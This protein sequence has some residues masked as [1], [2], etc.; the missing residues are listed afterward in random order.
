MKRKLTDSIV[1][2]AKPKADGK[3][4]HLTD[5]G[6]LFLLVNQAGKYW[7]YNYRFGGK[8][9]TL[10]I[11]TYPEI[12]LKD[13]RR[14]HEEAR[15][16]LARNIDPSTFKQS[17]QSAR[18]EVAANSFEAVA[19]EWFIKH[20]ANK[21]ETHRYRTTSYLERDVFPFLGHRPISEIRPK[22]IIPVIERI[23]RRV[24]HDSH[25][26][27][28]Q[29]IGQI[30]RYAVATDRAEID[31]TASLKGL[32]TRNSEQEHFPAITDPV[33]V[34]RLLRA[35]DHYAGNFLTQCALKLSAMVMLRPA[36]LIRAEWQEIDFE[37]ETWTIEVRRM[38]A[39][40]KVKQA[41]QHRH[42]IPL[43]SQAL[44]IFADLYLLTGQGKQVFPGH[45]K[46]K[47]KSMSDETV[48]KALYRMGFKGQMTAHGF[49]GMASTLLNSM[50]LNGVRRWDADAIERQLSH[51]DKNAIR[52][53]YNRADY[54][55]ERREMLQVWAD[56]LDELKAGGQV[57]PFKSGKAG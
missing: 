28:L 18:A 35:I 54:L 30:C 17:Q 49:R 31:P 24:K 57:I 19:R 53:A 40:T 3:P 22:E 33:E 50:R 38:K 27:V 14:R 46:N 29:S 34:G 56:H 9:K 48:L 36:E 55:E 23:Q 43:S 20:L 8:A 47:H 52:A 37:A 5:G 51:K 15:A 32:F 39:D 11:G 1:K 42:V 7:R 12:S 13:A 26:R 41:N 6:G 45:G 21:S 16:L 10:A 2:F 44:A 25:V 4:N